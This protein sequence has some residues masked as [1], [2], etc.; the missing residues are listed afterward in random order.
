MSLFSREPT[1]AL[2]AEAVV[3]RTLERFDAAEVARL[4]AQIE[5]MSPDELESLLAK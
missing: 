5:A 4:Q 1:V 2:L 3:E